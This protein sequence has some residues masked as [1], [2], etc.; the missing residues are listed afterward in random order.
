M[1]A[2]LKLKFN[3]QFSEGVKPSLRHGRSPHF[4]KYRELTARSVI[5]PVLVKPDD[6]RR[7][8][9]SIED[10]GDSVVAPLPTVGFEINEDRVIED[11]SKKGWHH[12]E[13]VVFR[14]SPHPDAIDTMEYDPVEDEVYDYL[15]LGI[16]DCE[17]TRCKDNPF[18]L[19]VRH[20]H[21]IYK[22]K[23]NGFHDMPDD[24]TPNPARRCV[25]PERFFPLDRNAHG[26]KRKRSLFLEHEEVHNSTVNVALPRKKARVIYD[27]PD[28]NWIGKF[29]FP[30]RNNKFTV[31]EESDVEPQEMDIF[32][33]FVPYPEPESV[34]HSPGSH[35]GDD[36]SSDNDNDNGDSGNVNPRM[37]NATDSYPIDDAD[38]QD[39]DNTRAG[40]Q[41]GQT[42]KGTSTSIVQPL[43]MMAQM[44]LAGPPRA[45][46]IETTTP[47]SQENTDS[48]GLKYLTDTLSKQFIPDQ[49][50]QR[51]VDDYTQRGRKLYEVVAEAIAEKKAGEKCQSAVMAR[52]FRRSAAAREK[53]AA[54]AADPMSRGV[55][56]NPGKSSPE[57]QNK[58]PSVPADIEEGNDTP[59][60][61]TRP[62]KPKNNYSSSSASSNNEE[63][64]PTKVPSDPRSESSSSSSYADDEASLPD[65]FSHPTHTFSSPNNP[66]QTTPGPHPPS[67]DPH[68]T[69]HE[70]NHEQGL[71]RLHHTAL[72]SSWAR[73]QAATQAFHA[74]TEANFLADPVGFTRGSGFAT[75]KWLQAQVNAGL[76]DVRGTAMS[77][78]AVRVTEVQRA[79]NR[80]VPVSAAARA[81]MAGRGPVPVRGGGVGALSRAPVRVPV[82]VREEETGGQS[83]G[84]KS[85]ERAES[86]ERGYEGDSDG[87]YEDPPEDI[88]NEGGDAV[89]DDIS[90]GFVQEN[91][92]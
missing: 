82:K 73:E 48:T 18:T 25:I 7:V 63:P 88:M 66:P 50:I 5:P 38:R 72:D 27:I 30:K 43:I 91:Y 78:A 32:V 74:E 68:F 59:T 84:E 60:L 57:E 41:Q 29:A 1:Q 33:K 11:E 58:S 10:N 85:G 46:E 61:P 15:G 52:I 51:F 6:Q 77:R 56:G 92:E 86:A 69:I 83:A 55:A 47:K 67:T 64:L 49:A 90:E 9:V 22:W 36:H 35:N 79:R 39:I 14:G 26:I 4:L 31:P 12:K 54:L 44:A 76:A 80:N 65:P 53:C 81:R 89:D 34:A 28:K 42:H 40:A 62:S 13:S 75:A 16:Y 17:R 8:H 87:E 70:V 24:F 19:P 20:K 37:N 21:P 3:N 2:H 23:D 71:A 45:P